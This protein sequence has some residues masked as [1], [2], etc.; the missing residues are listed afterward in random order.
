VQGWDEFDGHTP[1]R[2]FIDAVKIKHPVT[3]LIGTRVP[4]VG[5]PWLDAGIVSFSTMQYRTDKDYWAKWFPADFITESFPGQFRNWFYSLI[6][7]STVLEETLPTKAILGFATLLDEKGEA[8]HKSKGNSIE[9]SE[10]ADK[11]GA[12]VMRWLYARQ[13]Y[14]DNLLFG[15]N[16]LAEVRR[17][18]LIPLWNVYSFFVQYANADKWEIRDRGLEIDTKSPITNLQSLDKWVLA[19]LQETVNSTIDN[20]DGYEAR[21]AVLAIEKFIDDLSNWY[22]R[23]SRERFWREGMDDDK[24]AAYAT[25]YEVLTTLVKLIAPITPFVTEAMWQNLQNEEW[26]M[27]YEEFSVHHQVYPTKRELTDEER[28]LLR[29]TA[30]ARTTVNLGHSVRAQSKVK[31]RQPLARLLVVA[32]EASKRVI[33]KQASIIKDE[34]NV[35]AI[36][37]VAEERELV[38]YKVLPDLK[39][40]GK[41]L[42]QDMPKVRNELAAMDAMQVAAQV[43]AGQSLQVNGVQIQP[44]ELIVQAIPR[45]GLVVAGENGIVAALDTV[46]TDDLIAEGLAREAVRRINDLRKQAGLDISDRIATTYQASSRLAGAMAG[47]ADYIKSETLSV[48]LSEGQ[49]SGASISDTFDG[50]T[51]VVSLV[52]M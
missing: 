27:K 52:K 22:V 25:L 8:M 37:F 16:S 35:K 34:L 42:G 43:K 48:S 38:S 18:V 10:A 32:D 14:D 33:H 4:D 1:H 45:E 29:D 40:L 13:K 2:P 49:P 5:N 11:A 26:R 31:V 21:T 28:Q 7:M 23:R 50:E 47:F 9:F 17:S 3:G 12:D 36:E 51:L 20:L 46:L 6:A 44:D 19:R 24:Q 15:Y 39:K 30:I 41:K